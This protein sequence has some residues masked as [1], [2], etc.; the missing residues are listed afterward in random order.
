[1]KKVITLLKI[2][3]GWF[4]LVPLSFIIPKKRNLIIVIGS[5]SRYFRDNSKYIYLYLFK[6]KRFETLFLTEDKETYNLLQSKNL[7]TILY[8]KIKSI[9][10]L[11]RAKTII[12]DDHL[13]IKKNKF[14]LTK[15]SKIVQLW[16]GTGIKYVELMNK[17]EGFYENIKTKFT[18]IL[19]GRFPNYDLITSP[20][21]YFSENFYKKSFRHKRIKITGYAR[22]DIL[23]ENG[24][25]EL[26]KIF[27]DNKVIEHLENNIE[28]GYK[29]II[30]LPTFR[31]KLN[32]KIDN[33]IINFNKLDEFC[34][35]NKIIFIIKYHSTITIKEKS[36]YKNIIF[37]DSQKDI[38]PILKL[39][40]ILITDYSSVFFDYLLLNKPI[41]FY[42]YDLKDYINEDRGIYL[43][44]E[45][46]T[47][48][49]KI[50]KFKD[51]LN[52]VELIINKKKDDYITKR[53]EIL[54]LAFK[55]KDNK[56]CERIIKEIENLIN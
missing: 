27:T 56:S 23:L 4:V 50:H 6:I 28:K 25:N 1:M 10:K 19:S 55:F 29:I 53:Q 43:D 39:S 45:S 49:I 48:G 51:L 12:I 17:D 35:K 8:P 20:S 30:Y 18:K 40:D 26:N 47:P 13:W 32:N 21:E 37:Y 31:D 5:A 46:I 2:I 14:Y 3:F 22:N 33:S 15:A 7:K 9:L 34:N 16:H 24:N 54:N 36:A 44:F 42:T 11:L 52:E 41:I 38:Y